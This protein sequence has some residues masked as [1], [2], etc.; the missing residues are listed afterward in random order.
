MTIVNINTLDGSS[1][2]T[3]ASFPEKG[4]GPGLIILHEIFGVSSYIKNICNHYSSLGYVVLCPNLFGNETSL[5]SNL[6][7][8]WDL[9]KKL[10]NN[11]NV[12]S[13]LRDVFA[14]LAH[15]RKMKECNGSVGSIGFGLGSRLSYLMSTRSDINCSVSYYG[16]GID[17]F[18]DEIHDIRSPFMIHIGE[19][20]KLVPNTVRKKLIKKL[21]LN[22]AIETCL[23]PMAEH[24]FA[25][26]DSPLYNEIYAKQ[27]NE[28][29]ELFLK[30]L[31][32]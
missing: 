9:A 8:N 29:T 15:I 19:K 13:G 10:Y 14:V 31:L 27:A 26:N 1:I 16:V 24:S 2:E 18:L 22:K 6:E 17:G 5:Q 28:K 3:Y 32:F 11:F 20:D 12:D 7:S 23:Y 30:N 21:S 4:S 25:R